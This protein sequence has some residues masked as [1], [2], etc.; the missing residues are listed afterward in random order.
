VCYSGE[1]MREK[2]RGLRARCRWGGFRRI[3]GRGKREEEHSLLREEGGDGA[4]RKA[5][6]S[7]RGAGP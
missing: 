7:A 5:G 2:E 4:E 3:S 1:R 6:R